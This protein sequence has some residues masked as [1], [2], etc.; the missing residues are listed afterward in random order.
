VSLTERALEQA[1]LLAAAELGMCSAAWLFAREVEATE[2]ADGVRQLRDQL[3]RTFPVLDAVCAGW[4]E[5]RSAPA[6]D[7]APLRPQLAGAGRLLV[8]GVESLWLDALLPALD[9]STRLGLLRQAELEPD[10]ERVAANLGGRAELV[11]LSGFQA[12]AG[13]RSVLLTFVYGRAGG[14]GTFATPTW[15]RVS[16]SDVRTQFRALVGWDV[17]RSPISTYPRWLVSTPPDAFTHLELA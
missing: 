17:L 14:G 9:P 4:E 1:F 6:I 3:G 7:V 11:D 16:G 13:P 8:V 15:L 2:G 5:R 10:W 12:W